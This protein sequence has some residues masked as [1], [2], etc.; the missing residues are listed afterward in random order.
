M[1]RLGIMIRVIRKCERYIGRAASGVSWKSVLVTFFCF[2]IFLYVMFTL[3]NDRYIH[4][5]AWYEQPAPCVTPQYIMDGMI[6]L[7]FLVSDILTK[8]NIS[9]VLC[10]GTLWGALR[11]GKILPWDNNVDVSDVV[12]FMLGS[13][14]DRF[15]RI[16]MKITHASFS[17]ILF[18]CFQIAEQFGSKNLVSFTPVLWNLHDFW[19]S[20]SGH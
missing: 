13:F 10:Y 5:L 18:F 3:I 7:S 6:Q 19:A 11:Q 4:H 16:Y 15:L 17:Y 12:I 8:L 1:A 2:V 9:H 14:V 20:S